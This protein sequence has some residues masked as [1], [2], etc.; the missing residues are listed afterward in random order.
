MKK[1]FTRLIYVTAFALGALSSVSAYAI[2]NDCV[3]KHSRAWCLL[4]LAG[5]SKGAD[6]VSAKK[7]AEILEKLRP[8]TEGKTSDNGAMFATFAAM[9]LLKLASPPP[10]FSFGG[11]AAMNLLGLLTSGPRA[12]ERTQ[13]FI[14]L[15]QSAVKDSEPGSIVEDAFLRASIKFLGTDTVAVQDEEKNPPLGARYVKR[16]YVLTGGKCGAEGCELTLSFVACEKCYFRKSTVYEAP[17]P[18]VAAEKVYVWKDASIG[19]RLLS[20]N[21]NW[22]LTEEE[23]REFHKNMPDWYYLYSPGQVSALFNG[24]Q[25]QLLIH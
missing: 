11:S 18:W 15:P 5:Y 14:I 10:G 24:D 3:E 17:P 19:F 1:I 2:D 21:N 4:D 7:A 22:V 20:Q 23:R 16:K 9:D 25:T 13:N 6:D 8:G 12:G